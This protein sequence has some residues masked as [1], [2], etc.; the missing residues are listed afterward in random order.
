MPNGEASGVR[1]AASQYPADVLAAMP[2]R[3]R[4]PVSAAARRLAALAEGGDNA[5]ALAALPGD[6]LQLVPVLPVGWTLPKAA[7]ADVEATV[8]AILSR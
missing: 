8:D 6:A 5:P 1:T 3:A 2:P 7:P 4:G